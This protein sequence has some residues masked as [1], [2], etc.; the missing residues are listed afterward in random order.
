M[1][2][3]SNL[4]EVVEIPRALKINRKTRS[5]EVKERRLDVSGVIGRTFEQGYLNAHGFRRTEESTGKINCLLRI[6]RCTYL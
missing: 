6:V 3:R 2:V 5:E 1:Y 4:D